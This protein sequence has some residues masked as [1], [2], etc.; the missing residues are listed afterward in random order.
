MKKLIALMLLG[1]FVATV[2]VSCGEKEPKEKPA[3][4]DKDKDKDKDK[5]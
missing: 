1:A 2:A 4:K 3:E 5:E